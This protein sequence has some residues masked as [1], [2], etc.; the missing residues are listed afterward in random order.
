M[1][2]NLFPLWNTK[3][4]FFKKMQYFEE[5]TQSTSFLIKASQAPGSGHHHDSCT[6]VL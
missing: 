4:E 1:H 6:I 3:G 5:N 2:M